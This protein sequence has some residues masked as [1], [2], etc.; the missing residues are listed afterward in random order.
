MIDNIFVV[1]DEI[2]KE[3]QDLL[4]NLLINNNDFPWLFIKD[5][6]SANS[7]SELKNYGFTHIFKSEK[8]KV[9]SSAYNLFEEIAKEACSKINFEFTSIIKCRSFLQTPKDNQGYNEPHVDFLHEHMVFLYY[10]NDTDGETYLF[11]DVYNGEKSFENLD[12]EII[13]KVMPKKGRGL[14]FNGNRFH[15][16]SYPS[17]TIRCIVN[18]DL[19]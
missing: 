14:F 5:V 13:K 4:E 1:D 3:K 8:G 6:T 10:V 15:A 11:N 12:L 2:S 9:V 16:S 17:K 7:G 19:I 18:F